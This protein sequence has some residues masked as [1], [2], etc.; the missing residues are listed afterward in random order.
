[1]SNLSQIIELKKKS[2]NRESLVI[3]KKKKN[4]VSRSVEF[5]DMLPILN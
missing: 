5:P 1:M 4:C 2:V 3:R